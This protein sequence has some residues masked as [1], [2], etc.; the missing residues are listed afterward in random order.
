MKGSLAV[1]ILGVLF[2]LLVEKDAVGISTIRGKGISVVDKIRHVYCW[3]IFQIGLCWVYQQS[4]F[5][6]DPAVNMRTI[7]SWLFKSISR[8]RVFILL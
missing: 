6:H 7:A 3:L 1:R 2:V 8:V 5:K 4:R